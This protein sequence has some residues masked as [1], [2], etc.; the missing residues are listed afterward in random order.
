MYKTEKINESIYRCTMPYKDIFTT[1]YIVKTECGALLFDV[2]SYDED[3]DN[4]I[5]PFLEA[6]E[7]EP[8]MLKHV[9]ISHN[10]KDH[11]GGLGAFMKKF[12]NACIISKS[13]EL[14]EKFADYKV[15]MPEDN[16]T[17]LDVLKIITIPGHTQDSCAVYDTRTNT[18]ISGDCLQ[19]YGLYG[20]GKWGCNISY[21]QEHIAALDK[22]RQMEI[23]QILTAHDYHPYGYCYEGETVAK[24]LDA[25]LAPLYEINALLLR[26]PDLGDERICAIYNSF[27]KPTLGVHVVTAVRKALC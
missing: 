12:P 8:E 22:L 25:C 14:K 6:S 19:L 20:S 26:N 3:I 1:V 18:I 11:A 5:L 27:D 15:Y 17:V 24:A 4:Y 9:F 13:P 7:I 23:S 10:H 21:V 16:D 2:G